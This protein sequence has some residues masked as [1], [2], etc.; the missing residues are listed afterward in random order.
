M[1]GE[2]EDLRA[3][4]PDELTSLITFMVPPSDW[5]LGDRVLMFLGFAW[6]GTKRA[7]GEV[8]IERLQAACPAD[9]AVLDPTRWVA[10]QSAFDPI[11]PNGVRAYWRNESFSR[12]DA[13]MIDTIVEQCGAQT[14]F[15]TAADLHHL[16]GAFGR[17]ADDD[18]AFPGRSAQYWLNVYGFWPDAADDAARIRWVK[19]CS[20]AM[21]PYALAGQY[22]NFLGADETNP[23]QKAL[24]AYG[25]AKLQRLIELK[26]RYDP[27]NLFRVN[28][29]I[30][31][32]PSL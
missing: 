28:H 26:R 20:D 29:N 16:G 6:A 30:P 8:A 1:P 14:W 17:V 4:V 5:E 13:R 3:D 23:T 10:F 32:G 18:T 15:G 22:I 2:Q 11:L 31:P 19:D 27:G 12:F 21:R 25:P 7:D 9:V 24:E